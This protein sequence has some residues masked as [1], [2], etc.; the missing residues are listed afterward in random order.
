MVLIHQH[1]EFHQDRDL[2]KSITSSML[3]GYDDDDFSISEDM[4]PIN[5]CNRYNGCT[6]SPNIIL[7]MLM[8]L[9]FHLQILVLHNIMDKTKSA[10]A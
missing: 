7:A 10:T 1:L 2:T 4:S 8:Q 9:D 3:M 5:E 6:K